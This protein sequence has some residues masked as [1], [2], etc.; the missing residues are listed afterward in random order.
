MNGLI[1]SKSERDEKEG[2]KE[3]EGG[4]MKSKENEKVSDREF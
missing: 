4:P 3:R 2:D 1:V